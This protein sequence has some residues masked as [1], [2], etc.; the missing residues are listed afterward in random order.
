MSERWVLSFPLG[1]RRFN[2]RVAAVI[3]VDGHVLASREDDDDYMM[4]P[5][6]RV[7]LGE[8]SALSL[9]REIAEELGMPGTVGA[10]LATSENFYHRAGEDFHEIGLFYRATLPLHAVPDGKAPW[11][12]REDEGHLLHNY[13]L[14]LA[15]D[16]LERMNLLPRWLPTFL[17]N[18]PANPAHIV[19]DERVEAAQ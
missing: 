7:E 18:L 8:A 6:G 16:A 5:G 12:V 19:F 11:L 2:Y 15:G 4:L 3:V 9:E 17:R 13:W 14:P 1:G 10:L